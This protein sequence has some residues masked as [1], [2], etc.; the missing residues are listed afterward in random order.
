MKTFAILIVTVVLLFLTGCWDQSEL[1]ERGFVLGTAIDQQEDQLELTVQF[2]RPSPMEGGGGAS[3]EPA[4]FHIFSQTFSEG[5]RNLVNHVGRRANWSHMQ[6]IVIGEETART[7]NLSEILDFF[8][9]EQEPRVTTHILIG[10]GKGSNY[11]DIKPIFEDSSGR[12][13][14]EIQRFSQ[15]VTGHTQETTMHD[16]SVQMKS[17]LGTA[18]IPYITK[19]GNEKIE[20]APIIGVAI[21]KDDK[22]IKDL[23]GTETQSL[24]VLREEYNR[25]NWKLPCKNGNKENI[26]DNI[27]VFLFGSKLS[28]KI[29]GNKVTVDVSLQFEVTIREMLCNLELETTEDVEGFAGYIE[30]Q[31]E[32]NLMNTLEILQESKVDAINLGNRVYHDNPKQWKEVKDQWDEL[33]AESQFVFDISV[34]IVGSEVIH[35]KPFLK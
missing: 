31:I 5:A 27:E 25:A 2:Y 20:T 11:L 23:S 4:N 35:Y 17:E 15:E 9:R 1:M 28:P 34:E 16:L 10:Q 6:V 13:L 14:R 7:R 32:K 3:E 19:S 18:I 22:M 30:E 21:I 12:Q 8:Y 33:F 24:L 29:E 26:F